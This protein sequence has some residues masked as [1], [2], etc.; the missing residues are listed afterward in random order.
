[1]ESESIELEENY[2]IFWNL[3]KTIEY[4]AHHTEKMKEDSTNDAIY[5][6]SITFV[7]SVGQFVG[8]FGVSS[9]V[10]VNRFSRV[11]HASC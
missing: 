3:N 9:P 8:H 4:T 1:M 10:L 11:K 6:V 5:N 7:Y 2:T